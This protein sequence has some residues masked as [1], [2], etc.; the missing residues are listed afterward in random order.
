MTGDLQAVEAALSKH[1]ALRE[2]PEDL[3]PSTVALVERIRTFPER[4]APLM[5]RTSTDR[6]VPLVGR[7]EAIG[8]LELNL[9][10]ASRGGIELILLTGEGGIGK[11]RVLE[12]IRRTARLKGFRVLS[13]SAVQVEQRMP[14]SA[15]TDALTGPE[16]RTHLANLSEP[17]RTLT[18]AF[19]PSH[20][21]ISTLPEV[22]PIQES[23]LSKRLLDA[24]SFLLRAVVEERPTLLTI[25][26][27]QWADDTTL[28]VLQSVKRR[29]ERGPI[30]IIG[31]T[32]PPREHGRR[33]PSQY[34]NQLAAVAS[35]RHELGS[36]SS[37]HAHRLIELTAGRPLP[38]ESK[39]RLE[40]LGG[41]NPF[42][43][44]ELTRDHLAGRLPL[45]QELG[46]PLPLPISLQELFEHRLDILS[47]AGR[48]VAE[49][50]AIRARPI[51][52]TDLADL[53]QASLD[54]TAGAVEELLRQRF[55]DVQRGRVSISH[56]LFRSAF[57]RQ[58]SPA[59]LAIRHLQVARHL[60]TREGPPVH[61]ELAL[62]LARAGEA[63]DA[64][65]HG[66]VA[67]RQ[68]VERGALMDATHLLRIVV[69]NE[70]DAALRAEAA[71]ELARILH[72]GR[73]MERAAPLLESAAR[74]LRLVG[75]RTQAL[76]L[77]IRRIES[78]V[79]AAGTPIADAVE[80]LTNIK[81][82]ARRE[83]DWVAVAMALDSQMRLFHQV[84]NTDGI[85][86]TFR[87]LRDCIASGDR[88]AECLAN[89]SL[90]MSILFG[91]PSEGL[92]AARE[93]V[94]I[95]D[96]ESYDQHLLKAQTRLIVVLLYRGQMGLDATQVLVAAARR[97]AVASGDLGQRLMLEANLGSYF[98]EE[99]HLDV[100]EATYDGIARAFRAAEARL[101]E[102]NYLVNRASL[103]RLKF[104]PERAARF[105]DEASRLIVQDTPDYML[106]TLQ[107][108]YGLV[109]MQQGR[110]SEGKARLRELRG[111]EN[112]ALHFD[113]T[114]I[115]SFRA[116]VAQRIGQ[117]QECLTYVRG[118]VDRL[119]ARLIWPWLRSGLIECKLAQR[120]GA[121]DLA[122]YEKFLATAEELNL[123]GTADMLERLQLGR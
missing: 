66:R 46:D 55:A 20:H 115:L 8:K 93:A 113:P 47:P 62:H 36:L 69:D 52:M 85:R 81:S 94:R 102:F 68:A 96:Q 61:A 72:V 116:T 74:Q 100:A 21:G 111:S 35:Y 99:G 60:L 83:G 56:E 23:G 105:L 3:H 92:V 58:V 17:W 108:E 95:A 65:H 82:E 77:D 79:E 71:S 40:A 51:S 101:P 48:A 90:A 24:F 1:R 53:A 15:L 45:N 103:A 14:L 112:S 38:P 89:A 16:I 73:D 22:P 32:R 98:A 70:P 30:A 84:G 57:Y 49:T 34:L 117:A 54:Q 6:P 88:E 50:L 10:R 44:I 67:A 9:D 109:A 120:A 7:E 19:L 97:R 63:K 39:D 13:A 12:E 119:E 118:I 26:D 29:W 18:A 114:S 31:T 11:T 2:E 106:D 4:G 43:L 123:R 107:A 5:A 42:F 41:G 28:A 59:R 122:R 27:L 87:E 37:R 33:W 121:M 110:V 75:R 64:A 78:L 25:D 80:R 91:D 104:D 76:R 86:G